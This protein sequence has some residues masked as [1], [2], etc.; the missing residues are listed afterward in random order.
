MWSSENWAENCKCPTLKLLGITFRYSFNG[1]R[2]GSS[3]ILCAHQGG[4]AM[5]SCTRDAPLMIPN[6]K[7]LLHTLMLSLIASNPN[8]PTLEL[9]LLN[10]CGN[11]LMTQ[12]FSVLAKF[13]LSSLS[14]M[15]QPTV[16]HS[17][18]SSNISWQPGVTIV[19]RAGDL[20]SNL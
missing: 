5:H 13:L 2:N 6:A 10:Y 7:S 16:P 3:T 8:C 4:T 9:V 12:C 20:P 18:S 1:H 15:N 17:K 11:F 19:L 14:A